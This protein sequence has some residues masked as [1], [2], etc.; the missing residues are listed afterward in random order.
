MYPP[1]SVPLTDMYPRTIY[2]LYFA[3][4]D[5]EPSSML[6]AEIAFVSGGEHHAN[7]GGD[8]LAIL[9]P[10]REASASSSS[11]SECDEFGNP[12]A[13]DGDDGDH[14]GG[15]RSSEV[16]YINIILVSGIDGTRLNSTDPAEMAAAA[17]KMSIDALDLTIPK[18]AHTEEEEDCIIADEGTDDSR[19]VSL[20]G[21]FVGDRTVRFLA[22]DGAG[23]LSAHDYD[24]KS[25][26]AS[27][28]SPTSTSAVVADINASLGRGDERWKV[29]ESLGI[30]V[31]G[32]HSLFLVAATQNSSAKICY[33]SASSLAMQAEYMLEADQPKLY[34]MAPISSCAGDVAA[35]AIAFKPSALDANGCIVVLQTV[36]DGD[37][38]PCMVFKVPIVPQLEQDIRWIDVALATTGIDSTSNDARHYSF[39]YKVSY[40]SGI[41]ECMTFCGD[42]GDVVG[43]FRRYLA[44]GSYDEA[45]ALLAS[46][47]ASSATKGEY[48]TIH[49]SEVALQRFKHIIDS[50]NVTSEEN[51]T[52]AKECLRRLSSGAVT[53]GD[54]GVKCLLDASSALLGWPSAMLSTNPEEC[55][56][57]R[58][59]RIAI[60]AM[61]ATVA[62]AM[63]A[64]PP[65]HLPSLRAE[66]MRLDSKLLAIRC[67]EHAAGEEHVQVD[68]MLANAA[69]PADVFRSLVLEGSWVAAE[70]VRRSEFA[71]SITPEHMASAV[72][73]LPATIDPRS[74]CSW[75]EKA[76]IPGLSI[77]HPILAAIRYWAC[78]VADAFDDD[79]GDNE[80]GLDSAI[81]LLKVRHALDIVE[82]WI[83]CT[84]CA[85]S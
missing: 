16:P 24:T 53:G 23:G 79:G 56:L 40:N 12:I 28:V 67:V 29:D 66:K 64:T 9:V 46:A 30:C 19:V 76:I 60:S 31:D 44:K 48:G 45:D 78:R 2:L 7:A 50:G 5:E 37:G 32:A 34:A 69:S 20:G 82:K 55:I 84:L 63:K 22:L 52:E 73:G 68:L 33:Y 75:L 6:P 77:N 49:G 10:P 35:A 47:G 27:L 11:S 83:A 57:T 54:R 43:R 8:I 85:L 3:Q 38:D 41:G 62:G 51:M 13:A 26:E 59:Y 61:S 65:A 58:D 36:I 21:C 18:A 25:K 17:S 1:L 15:G 4:I 42:A 81:T 14:N 80:L 71:Q 74:Y 70:K 72:V 39:H